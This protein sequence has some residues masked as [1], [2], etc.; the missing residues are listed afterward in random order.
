MASNYHL[1]WQ[2]FIEIMYKAFL[3]RVKFKNYILFGSEVKFHSIFKRPHHS[4]F[5]FCD[6]LV[7]LRHYEDFQIMKYLISEFR[8]LNNFFAEDSEKF[9]LQFYGIRFLK[10]IFEN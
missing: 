9:I 5:L 6:C 3:D 2:R 8:Y 1:K 7:N 10:N 4:A